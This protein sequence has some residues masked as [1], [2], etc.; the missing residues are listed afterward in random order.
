MVFVFLL[1]VVYVHQLLIHIRAL[2]MNASKERLRSVL[3]GALNNLRVYQVKAFE[4][5]S[6]LT[7]I[8]EVIY[9]R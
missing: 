6:L 3:T 8:W 1:S 7:R 9:Y 4:V 2:R 5:T